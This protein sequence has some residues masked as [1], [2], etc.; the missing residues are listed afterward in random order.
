M[1][2]WMACVVLKYITNICAKI[3][4]AIATWDHRKWSTI[5]S[6]IVM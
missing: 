5:G 3:L 2:E 1:F 6:H 4:V